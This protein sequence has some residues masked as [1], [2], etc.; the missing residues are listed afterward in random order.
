MHF[1]GLRFGEENLA[2]GGK[3]Y[4]NWKITSIELYETLETSH[5]ITANFLKVRALFTH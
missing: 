5:N 2:I 3:I 4:S 1:P